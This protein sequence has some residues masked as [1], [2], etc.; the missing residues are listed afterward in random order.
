MRYFQL[1]LMIFFL[2]G[3]NGNQLEHTIDK[4]MIAMSGNKPPASFEI[5]NLET[6]KGYV[7]NTKDFSFSLP[8]AKQS[9]FTN[10]GGWYGMSMRDG[11]TIALGFK[12]SIVYHI[13]VS[14]SGKIRKHGKRESAISNNNITYLRTLTPQRVR[15]G[16]IYNMNLKTFHGGKE[17]YSCM[18]TE[19]NFPKYGKRKISYGCFKVNPSGTLVKGA[20]ITLTYNKPKNQTLAKQYTYQDLQKR[21]KRVLDSL[22]IKDGW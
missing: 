11:K 16:K 20:G 15:K 7:F 6:M 3:C 8:S 1:L 4:G 2:L 17:N 12:N 21:A 10:M 9:D 5:A 18:V 14:T 19:S 13:T 22:Y